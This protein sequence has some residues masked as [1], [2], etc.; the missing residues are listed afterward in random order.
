MRK[1]NTIKRIS[2][3]FMIILGLS[4]QVYASPVPTK[5]IRENG[6][7]IMQYND[8]G[9]TVNV[10]K[11][12]PNTDKRKIEAKEKS[13]LYTPKATT[14]SD[15]FSFRGCAESDE[16]PECEVICNGYISS[17]TMTPF[18]LKV[19]GGKTK[20]RYFGSSDPQGIVL[21]Q[22]YNFSGTAITFGWPP[23]FEGSRTHKKW[24]SS[25]YTDTWRVD[26]EREK[27][28]G[29]SLISTFSVTVTDGSDVYVDNNIYKSR[30]S[31]KKGVW[32]FI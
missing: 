26:A 6:V 22:D 31:V 17:T 20:G 4:T 5:I 3:C 27:A 18:K 9:V 15:A 7:E 21:I 29:T 1:N 28:W 12:N 32:N 16:N 25:K 13:E 19:Y 24:V 10:Y 14:R 30:Y 23:S 11:D 8:K 2:I